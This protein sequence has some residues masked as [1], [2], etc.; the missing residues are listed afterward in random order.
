M[1]QWQGLAG[2]GQTAFKHQMR[3]SGHRE[4]PLALAHS[5]SSGIS[6]PGSASV[7]HSDSPLI[8]G[9][10]AFCM[11]MVAVGTRLAS[12]GLS[13]RTIFL[14]SGISPVAS[15]TALWLSV[16]TTSVAWLVAAVLFAGSGQGL[17]HLGGFTMIALNASANRR[18]EA[19][20]LMNVGGYAQ[21]GC[22]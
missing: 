8:A 11:F 14:L 4:V 22:C 6:S 3:R 20:G 17:G 12:R 15:M 10:T 16:E 7:L 13:V 19:N 1:P 5:T 18:S 9:T 2:S 21:A